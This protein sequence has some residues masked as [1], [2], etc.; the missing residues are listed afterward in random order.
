MT[1][2][3]IRC[4]WRGMAGDALYEAY[5]D[6]EWGVPEWDSRALWEK[7]V[8]D[9]FQA[10]LAWITILRKREAFRAA[11]AGFDPEIVARFGEA[12]RARLMADPGI[13]RSNAKIDAAISGARIYLDMREA[14]EDFSEFLWGM[15]GAA[16]IQNRFTGVGEVPAQT[17][18]AQEM[19]KALKAKGFKFCG[20][21]IVY[22]FMQAVGMVN[23]HL[24]DCFR[25]EPC[26]HLGHEGRR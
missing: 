7:L 4:G 9:G 21:V 23:D 25:H 16:P 1:E 24:T 22:A 15:V 11:F 3:L 2:S 20:P 18:L 13:V 26:A 19:A 17:P 12:D 8:L 5:H 10:G 14:G 6:T